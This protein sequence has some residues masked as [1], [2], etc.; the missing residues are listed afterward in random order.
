MTRARSTGFGVEAPQKKCDDKNC[1]FHGELKIRGKKF[2]GK[3]VSH[4][5][6]RSVTV[7]WQGWRFIPKYERYKKTRTKVIAHN[8]PCIDAVEGDLVM[9]GEC[10][11]LSKRKN[12]VVMKV[13]AKLEKY[14]V[15]K[16]A[17]EEGRHKK[18]EAE[19][20]TE[21]A[22]KAEEA[23]EKKEEAEE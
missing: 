12:F 5:M 9:I 15:E 18:K 16:E 2:T 6:Q 11:P 19:L 23:A 14:A 22:Q 4:K 10:K 20:R 1:P 21:R 7:E 8:P 13:L 17:K 3:V